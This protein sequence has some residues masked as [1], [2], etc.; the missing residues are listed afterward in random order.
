MKKIYVLE[1]GNP[2]ERHSILMYGN[3]LL[4]LQ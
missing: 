4:Q 2:G 3:C 1:L